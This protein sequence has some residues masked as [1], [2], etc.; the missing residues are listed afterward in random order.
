[1]DFYSGSVVQATEPTHSGH[2]F[3]GPCV[4]QSNNFKHQ[5]Q[6]ATVTADGALTSVLFVGVGELPHKTESLLCQDCGN[7]L[8]QLV[9]VNN[10][11]P[12][13]SSLGWNMVGLGLKKT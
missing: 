13:V 1:M 8:R 6:E 9:F 2:F 3:L 5:L 7:Y 10:L 12:W 4:L 11:S